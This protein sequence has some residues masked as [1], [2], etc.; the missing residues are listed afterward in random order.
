MKAMVVHTHGGPEVLTLD[1]VPLPAPAPDQ[2]RVR[3]RASSVN[4]LDC[5]IR[6]GA[7]PLGAAPPAI[8][9]IDVAGT[10]G[11]VGEAV[12][13]F[14]EGDRV[15]GFAGGVLAYPGALAEYVCVPAAALALIPATMEFT[16]A[17]ALPVA[18]CTA[19]EAIHERAQVQAGERVLVQGGA[20]GVGHLA[21]QLA[22]AC[23]AEVHATVSTAEK[24]ELVRALGAQVAIDYRRE[25]V[26]DMVRAHTDGHGYDVVID[27]VGGA[28]LHQALLAAKPGGRVVSIAARG[29]HDLSPMHGKG[30]RLDVVFAIRPLVEDQG[31][32]H[33][34]RRLRA[35]AAAFEQGHLT[36]HLHRQ[37]YR[38][39]E[40]AQA[41]R[42]L[43]AGEALGKIVLINDL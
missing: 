35:V 9:H 25:G 36:P 13:G 6:S 19:W 12:S 43:E 21:V 17:A 7:L 23:G 30:L 38:F 39:S 4:P 8:L 29:Q 33:L 14:E 31:F 41:H 11:A 15:Y 24:A 10:V 3:V 28:A 42:C 22:H 2:V 18:A 20:G 5:K 32:A 37:I 34:G 26:S 40:V 16:Q 27:T 1:V